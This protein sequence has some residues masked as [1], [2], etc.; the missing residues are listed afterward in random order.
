MN[1]AESILCDID[2][3]WNQFVDQTPQ[4]RLRTLRRFGDLE[5]ALVSESGYGYT[6]RQWVTLAGVINRLARRHSRGTEDE[7]ADIALGHASI[8]LMRLQMRYV[9]SMLQ[10]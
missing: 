8:L 1:L 10:R 7:Q 3:V 6:L 4:A 5:T 2:V 9:G